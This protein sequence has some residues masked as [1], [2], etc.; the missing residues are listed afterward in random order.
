MKQSAGEAMFPARE[1]L[2]EERGDTLV[3]MALSLVLVL[4]TM[5]GIIQF[6]EALY[7]CGFVSWAAQQGT[8]YAV[9]RGSTWSGNSCTSTT[10]LN[11]DAT[12]A[13]ITSYV[14]GLTPP[15]ITA[16]SLT[17]NATW[18][19]YNVYQATSG[20]GTTNSPGCVVQLQVSYQFT[21]NLPFVPSSQFTFSSTSEQ[22]IQ[23]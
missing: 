22:A 10:T 14:Q 19:G 11:C 21:L 6:S 23:E 13:N 5:F 18:P 9:V 1:L 7:A 20:C 16:G 4:A 17:V 15:G 3:E 12:A 8:R 2:Q